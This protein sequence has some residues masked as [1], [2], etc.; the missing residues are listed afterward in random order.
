MK[1]QV[2]QIQEITV[3]AYS[4]SYV[5]LCNPVNC[6]LSGSSVHGDS[7]GRNSGVACHALLQE[8]FPTQLSNG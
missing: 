6:S 8:I 3:C 4:F 1:W 7:P 5:Q 2:V